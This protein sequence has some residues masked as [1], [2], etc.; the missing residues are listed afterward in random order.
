MEQSA[1]RACLQAFGP[2][3]PYRDGTNER[4]AFV[5]GTRLR[6]VIRSAS[7]DRRRSPTLPPVV[8]LLSCWQP[9]TGGRGCPALRAC[10]A[11]PALGVGRCPSAF[12]FRN[13]AACLNRIDRRSWSVVDAFVDAF[14]DMREHE[15]RLANEVTTS[16]GCVCQWSGNSYLAHCL[17]S[18]QRANDGYAPFDQVSEANS[19]RRQGRQLGSPSGT[20]PP[21]P[22]LI[23]V[24]TSSSII[25]QAGR[26]PGM[27]L[28]DR[29]GGRPSRTNAACLQ[30][31]RFEYCAT[32]GWSPE[33]TEAVLSPRQP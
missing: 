23:R 3:S 17:R 21:G 27:P 19:H 31:A 5:P 13:E 30:S 32:P 10:R 18:G 28:A 29:R 6:G 1:F 11:R 20:T 16:S 2:I 15:G 14:E 7:A 8:M 22:N 33:I 24:A 25:G 12:M 26:A 9:V 4:S